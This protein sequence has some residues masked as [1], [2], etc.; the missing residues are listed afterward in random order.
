[1]G[2]ETILVTGAAGFTGHHFIAAATAAGYR[3]VA[4]CRHAGERVPGASDNLHCDLLDAAALPAAVRRANP[5]MVVH[6]AAISFVAHAGSTEPYEVNLLGTLNLL[7]ALAD[8]ATGLR[9]VLIASSANIYG[10][11]SELPIDEQTPVQPVNHYGVSK[12]AMELAAGL[13]RQLPLVIARPFNYTGAGQPGNFLVPKLVAAFKARRQRV[14]LG[15]LD[16][17]RDYSDVR[18]VVRAY[19]GLL[20]E[21][22]S[23]GV[24]NVCSGRATILLS[25]VAMLNELAGYEIEVQS[26]AELVRAEEIRCLYG[27]GRRLQEA[28]G[29]YRQFAL[30]DTLS[31]MLGS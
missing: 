29:E 6:L 5:A 19:L 24:Y 15:N 30:R 17:A 14:E 9:K 1:M 7:D 16:V 28:I 23:A 11:A 27:S 26:R 2:G 8:A 21:P 20:A 18:D 25:I 4:L 12:Y 31:W 3:C 22:G 13:Y 10:N